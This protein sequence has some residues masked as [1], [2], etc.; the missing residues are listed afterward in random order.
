M[1]LIP[2]T[3]EP[4]ELFT[5]VTSFTDLLAKDDSLTIPHRNLQ[6]LALKCLK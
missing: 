4:Y 5:K 1:A 6:K 2:Y 3:R